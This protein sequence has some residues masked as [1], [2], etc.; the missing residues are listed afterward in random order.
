MRLCPRAVVGVL[1]GCLVLAAGCKQRVNEERTLSLEPGVTKPLQI[2]A[3]ARDQQV[4][5]TVASPGAPVS[6][7]LVLEK[8]RAATEDALVAG[9]KP[10]ANIL[11]GSEKAEQAT[12]EATVPAKEAYAVVVSNSSGKPAQ[13]KVTI[14]GQ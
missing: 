8:N 14:K 7:Y 11:A 2:D 4:T 6:A 3:P 5:V 13:V 9:K 10:G 1:A 12:L